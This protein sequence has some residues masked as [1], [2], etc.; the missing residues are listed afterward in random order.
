MAIPQT[1]LGPAIEP[2]EAL[3]RLVDIVTAYCST[4]AFLAGCKLG[5]F[6][7]LSNGAGSTADELAQRLHIHPVACRRLLVALASMGLVDREGDLYCN[8]AVGHYCSSKASVNLSAIAGFGEPFYHMFEFFPD[9]LRE[10]S[11]R[12][13]QA[14]GTSKEDVFGALY[15]D[16]Q[17]LRNFAHFMNALSIPQGQQIAEHF[18]FS[19]YTCIMDVAGGP[20]GQ[21]VQIGLRHTHLR[22][23]IMDMAPVCE[24]AREY[25][26]ASGLSD[27]FTSV[28]ADL[29][30]GGYPQGAD[31]ILLG[32]ILHDWSD[33]NCRK[34]LRNAFDALPARGLLLISESVL[35]PDYSG[36]NFALMKD[37]AMMVACESEAR[38]RTEAEYRSLLEETG[39]SLHEVIRMNAPRDLVVAHKR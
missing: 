24:I 1:A 31:V 7:E 21:A 27:R 6:E 38:E 18:D 37:L 32:H 2:V 19:P 12:W 16:P 35:A 10:Y 17:R 4:Q 8:S 25:I 28:P 3:N 36:S 23:I 11:P 22:G 33:E 13:Q 34:I 5:V 9:A 39:F 26:Q 29:F 30:T 15:E 20:G 14:L